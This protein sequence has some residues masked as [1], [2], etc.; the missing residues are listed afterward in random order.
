MRGIFSAL[1]VPY[2]ENGNIKE[3]GLKQLV[4]YNID[5][6]GVDGLYVGGSTGENFMLSTDEKK[7]IFEIV[8]DEA[9]EDVDLIAQ[10][11]SINLKRSEEHTSELQSRQYL[12][13]RLLLEKKNKNDTSC[14]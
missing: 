9:K 4:R 5:V 3:E 14:R 13:C 10:V 11:G 12:V 1:L 6:C 7:K 2:D 8:K